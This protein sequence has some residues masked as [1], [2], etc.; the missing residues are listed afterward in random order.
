MIA[1]LYAEP[2]SSGLSTETLYV[3]RDSATDELIT[4]HRTTA[5][6]ETI[7]RAGGLGGRFLL[8]CEDNGFS[9]ADAVAWHRLVSHA[10]IV[11]SNIPV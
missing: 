7:L 9:L 10:C 1:K 11:N 4:S 3:I 2:H 8:A 6:M 5:D